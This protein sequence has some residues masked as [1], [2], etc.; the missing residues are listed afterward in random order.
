M[1][2]SSLSPLLPR[3]ES[4]QQLML[5]F[6]VGEQQYALASHHIQEILPGLDLYPIDIDRPGLAG[7]MN[8]HGD[9]I[10]VLDLNLLMKGRSSRQQFGTRIVLLRPSPHRPQIAFLAERIIDMLTF[11]AQSLV[12]LPSG[13][14]QVPYLG[15][16]FLRDQT[17]IRT[18]LPQG[19]FLETAPSLPL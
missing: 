13:S 8:Y 5:L 7:L 2:A 18:F 1:M 4:A 3:N 14:D 11:G 6:Q 15:P 16:A 10:P 12:D 9:M 19:L 17:M